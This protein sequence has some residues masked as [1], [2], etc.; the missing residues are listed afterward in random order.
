MSIMCC[1][2]T[3]DGIVLAADSRLTRT[4]TTNITS[5]KENDNIEKITI[6]NTTYTLSDNA[7]KVMLLKKNCVG[8]SFCGDAIIQG[9]NVSDFIR[10]FEIELVSDDDTTEI[11]AEKLCK[12]YN[13]TKTIFFVCGYDNDI[14]YVYDIINKTVNR[15]NIIEYNEKD[16]SNINDKYDRIK[17][18]AIWNGHKTAITKFIN[19]EPSINLD[20]N[21]MPLK[22]SIEFAEFLVDLTIKYERFSDDIQTCGGPIDVLVITKDEAY[23]VNHKIY[24]EK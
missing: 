3:P 22:D 19:G 16:N 8:I 1:V 13:D 17:Y 20:F 4:R 14:P 2:Y 23:W 9:I 10:K 5:S 6:E 12:Y 11:I 15:Q 7:Q 24:K 18:S 21:T